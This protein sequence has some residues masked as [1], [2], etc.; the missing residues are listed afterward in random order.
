MRL[1]FST[2]SLYSYSIERC[3]EFASKAGFDGM[4]LMIDARWD[5][6]QPDYLNRLIQ[7]YSLPIV[8][9]HSPFFGVPGW[10]ADQPSLI[11]QSL[12]LAEAVEARVVVHHLPDRM[13]LAHLSINPRQYLIPLIWWDRHRNYRIWLDTEYPALQNSTHVELCIENMPAKKLFGYRMNWNT[14]NTVRDM[15]RFPAL[16]MD[17]THLAT[18]ALDPLEVYARWTTR[19]RHVHLSNY[20]GREHRRPEDG[21]LRLDLLLARLVEDAYAGAVSLELHPDALNA[22]AP[23]EEVL[24]L[25]SA[26][27]AQCRAWTSVKPPLPIRPATRV[28]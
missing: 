28:A 16:T 11:K 12:A 6:R 5:T 18:W 4:E 7:R 23:D 24:T 1:I 25:L 27:L 2:G 3:F 22:G 20:N 26:S 10:P 17:T 19:V 13:G 21:Q 8:A 15:L 14:W 9:V